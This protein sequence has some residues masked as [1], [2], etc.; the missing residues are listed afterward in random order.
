[1]RI[2]FAPLLRVDRRGAGQLGIV[3]HR[4][5]LSTLSLPRSLAGAA[6]R[7]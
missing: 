2:Q 4:F 5:S 6:P 3:G 7:L 1:L